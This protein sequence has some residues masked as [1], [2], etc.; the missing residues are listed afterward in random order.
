M[1][2]P[3]EIKQQISDINRLAKMASLHPNYSNRKWFVAY[4]RHLA[5][6]LEQLTSLY[7]TF[8]DGYAKKIEVDYT[9]IDN[10]YDR[11]A[12]EHGGK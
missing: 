1:I 10:L 8:I 4:R 3:N 11:W 5:A 7:N 2:S 9:H 6:C 12:K